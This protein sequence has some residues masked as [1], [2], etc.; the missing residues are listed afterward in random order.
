MG[1]VAGSVS[2]MKK[3]NDDAT[4]KIATRIVATPLRRP[5]TARTAPKAAAT[6]RS[7]YSIDAVPR[8]TR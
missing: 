7:A 2:V 5:S 1:T 3:K 8:T 6:N 4:A